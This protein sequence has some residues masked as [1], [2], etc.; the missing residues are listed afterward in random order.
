MKFNFTT[1]KRIEDNRAEHK[2]VLRKNWYAVGN[3]GSKSY[4]TNID[5]A[6]NIEA[7]NEATSWARKNGLTL[8]VVRAK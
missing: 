5:N 3:D 2:T 1:G 6:L 8:E 7:H 4:V